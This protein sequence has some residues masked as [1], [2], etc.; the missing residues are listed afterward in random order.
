MEQQQI[1]DSLQA[2]K[3]VL[4]ETINKGKQEIVLKNRQLDSLEKKYIVL[5]VAYIDL[6]KNVYMQNQ[7]LQ[8]NKTNYQAQIAQRD[9]LL[10]QIITQS[11]EL[12]AENQRLQSTLANGTV[13]YLPAN[14]LATDDK[15]AM[16]KLDTLQATIYEEMK[17]FIGKEMSFQRQNDKIQ[18]SLAH[19]LLFQGDKMSEDGNFILNL[20][21]KILKRE[22][23]AEITILNY[24]NQDEA[25]KDKWEMS[26]NQ[27][28]VAMKALKNGGVKDSQLRQ[29]NMVTPNK[30]AT[31]VGVTVNRLDILINMK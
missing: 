21:A 13:G 17:N 20:L 12:L 30:I 6:E 27:F 10:R 15:L 14:S 28:L 2:T 26:M 18:L 9:S 1:A 24:A 22:A 11:R 8:K 5:H 29:V 31:E 23:A 3:G 25:E 19:S 4:N 16:R 7:D